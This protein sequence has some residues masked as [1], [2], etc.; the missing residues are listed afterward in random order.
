MEINKLAKKPEIIK[1]TVDDAQVVEAYGEPIVFWMK[2]FVDI[3]TYFQFFQS[4]ADQ[5]KD[6]RQL[7]RILKKIVLKE[8]G[9]P[10]I[11]EDEELPL[12]VIVPVITKVTE[13]LGKLK[14]KLSTPIDGAP[15]E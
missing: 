1:V 9:D 13:N 11:A 4:Q 12:N 15:Q 3:D 2:D 8:N 7:G 6:V 14:T 5:E 10:A